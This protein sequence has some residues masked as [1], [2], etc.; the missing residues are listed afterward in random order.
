MFAELPSGKRL[1]FDV[2][3]AGLAVNGPRLVGRPTLLLVH[4]S[5]VDHS[6]FKPWV[7]PLADRA[8]L[9]YVDL[10][11]HGRSDPGEPDDWTPESWAMSL[12]DLADVLGIGSAVVLGSSM[13]GRVAMHLAVQSP[14]LVAGLL[15]VNTVGRPRPDRRIEMFMRLGGDA[16]AEAARRSLG[17][18]TAST[19]TSRRSSCGWLASGSH[20]L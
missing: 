4:G 7:S 18:A 12:C 14:D 9:V 11:G 3:G 5:E 10:L 8:Q 16:A 1:F 20:A 17:P 2:E 15:L 6:F 13:G 19:A